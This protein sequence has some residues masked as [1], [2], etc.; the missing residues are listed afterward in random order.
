MY[1]YVCVCSGFRY[2]CSNDGM[3]LLG[4][5]ETAS[6]KTIKLLADRV[7][8]TKDCGYRRYGCVDF[9]VAMA[10]VA[11][12]TVAMATVAMTTVAMAVESLYSLWLQSLW[13]Q[14]LWL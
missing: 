3:L 1:V 12:A 10:T 7:C 8:N 14:S 11:M 6:N 9:I 5:S 13:L 4:V 2:V